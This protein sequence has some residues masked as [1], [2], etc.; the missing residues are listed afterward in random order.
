MLSRLLP[1][2]GSLREQSPQQLL[3]PWRV[4]T[5]LDLT[6]QLAEEFLPIRGFSENESALAILAPDRD[7]GFG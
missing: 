1:A 3:P 7:D 5:T 2:H 4:T 6:G